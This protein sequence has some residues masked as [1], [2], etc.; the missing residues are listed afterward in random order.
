MQTRE[1]IMVGKLFV[2][3]F[4]IICLIFLAR[5][6]T[7]AQD[8]GLG[9]VPLDPG[10][11]Q[12]YLR[13]MPEDM[14]IE[15]PTNY[16]AR[17]EG[18]VT[19]AKYQGTC[20]SCWSYASVAALE[21]HLLKEFSFGVTDLSEQ[22]QV[23]CNFD[24]SGCCGGDMSAIRYWETNGPIYENCFS[25]AESYTLCPTQR[26]AS[27]SDADICEEL[28]YHVVNWH[29][30]I[31]SQFKSSLYNDGPSY[32]RFNVYSDFY[33]FWNTANN[34]DVYIHSSGSY[35]GGHAV[36]LIGWDDNK[37]AY[38]C[39]NSWGDAA[40]PNNDGT[41]WISYSGHAND[42]GFGMSN[43]SLTGGCGN[44]TCDFGEDPCSC[45]DDCGIPLA[46][47]EPD[48]TCTDGEDNDCD[49][50]ADCM[51]ND[52][53][54]DSAC[55]CDDDGVCE[56]G[57]NCRNCPNDCILESGGG[58]DNGVCEPDIGENCLTCPNDCAGKQKGKPSQQFCCGDGEGYNPVECGDVRCNSGGYLCGPLSPPS[59][60]GDL[61]CEETESKCN[62]AVDCGIP[63]SNEIP[64]STCSDGLDNDCDGGVDCEDQTGDCDNDSHCQCYPKGE[65]CI[66]NSNCCSNW[67][68]RW[69]C[70]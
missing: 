43:F 39:K 68:H 69:K 1:N 6:N 44:G 5:Q 18:I 36:L 10:I 3:F 13:I 29:T 56:S 65:R 24:M 52:C 45:P 22:Q 2:G 12:K 21:S 57:E 41:F 51:D 42:L 66:Y 11:Y 48:M 35:E 16:D 70:K 40:G 19:P 23:S 55:D 17:D 26:T 47:E 67:C 61:S 50:F 15:I 46:L 9:D 33:T 14:A 59:C 63:S 58:C 4:V 28:S 64:G 20:G 60:C 49:G 7:S 34:G 31:E 54:S 32:W 8:Y 37:S 30:L 25:Y 62:C 53:T 38:L 27:C